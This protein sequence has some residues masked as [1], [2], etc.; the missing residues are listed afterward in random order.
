LQSIINYAIRL[1]MLG[2]SP[3]RGIN[4]PKVAPVRSHVV[5]AAEL[6]R[7]AKALGGVEGMGPMVYLGAVQGLRW[8]EVAGLRVGRVDTEASTVAVI[9][10]IVRGRRGSV[11]V[12]QP[13]SDAGRRTLALPRPLVEMLAVHMAAV[14]LTAEDRE[15]LLFTAPGGGP[16]RYTNW[17]RR[18]WYPATIATGLG[19]MV[20]DA[21]TG[22]RRYEGLGFHDLRR[23]AA[24][25]L[26]GAGVDVKTAQSVL[27]HT[28]ARVTL[29]LYAQVVTEQQQ[30]AADA[31]AARFLEPTPRG[32]RGVEAESGALPRTRREGL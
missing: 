25:G 27:G 2:R 32:R 10:T 9:E 8:G 12:G 15:A 6:A 23:A 30:A 4:L 19:Q 20:E 14:G 22:R 31:M 28:D 3:C 7:L 26:V 21:A 17:L 29:D 5:D 24:T 18:S 1:D 16:L 13:K 11:G